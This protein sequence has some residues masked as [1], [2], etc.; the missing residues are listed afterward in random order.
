MKRGHVQGTKKETQNASN[1]YA[2]IEAANIQAVEDAERALVT[3]LA[4][5]VGNAVAAMPEAASR[6]TKAA[7]LVQA[8][9]VWPLTSG[10]YLV[11]SQTDALAAYLVRRGPWGCTCPDHTYSGVTC[12]HIAAVWL[13]IKVGAAYQANYEMPG[14][15]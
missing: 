14:A 3:A 15:A 6:I 13:T 5:Q 10:S 2:E 12:T 7:A 8:G 11:G 1:W 9:Q 4:T